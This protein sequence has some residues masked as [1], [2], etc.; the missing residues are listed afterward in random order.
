MTKIT[1]AS[2]RFP[3]RLTQTNEKAFAAQELIDFLKIDPSYFHQSFRKKYKPKPAI[4]DE[5]DVVSGEPLRAQTLD[6]FSTTKDAQ[7]LLAATSDLADF[8][9]LIVREKIDGWEAIAPDF[10]NW[11]K[12]PGAYVLWTARIGASS[13]VDGQPACLRIMRQPV[14]SVV[15]LDSVAKAL[16]LLP[17]IDIDGDDMI[18]SYVARAK[19]HP[20]VSAGREY[21]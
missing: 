21:D 15:A 14:I 16:G 11:H 20:A 3:Q 18:V 9:H 19:P 1:L 8:H 13:G 7:H 12:Y 6:I 10:V 5:G 2:F 17:Q 4:P